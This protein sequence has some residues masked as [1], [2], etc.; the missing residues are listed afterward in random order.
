MS[1]LQLQKE[2]ILEVISD[3]TTTYSGFFKTLSKAQ[4]KTLE[5]ELKALSKKTGKLQYQMKMIERKISVQK[6][7]KDWLKVS[8]L[9]EELD[10]VAQEIITLGEDGIDTES[11]FQK[12]LELQV[13]D[14]DILNLGKLH[15][16]Q[17]VYELILESTKELQEGK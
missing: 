13:N 17:V 12:R 9:T 10:K 11:V 5:K 16:Y 3:E 4:E 7:L 1:K 15:G 2:W 6:Q 14:K 8:K